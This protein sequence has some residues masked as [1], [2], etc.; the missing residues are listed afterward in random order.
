MERGKARLKGH[1]THG[2]TCSEV[3]ELYLEN[4]RRKELVAELA[5]E[6]MVLKKSLL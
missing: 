5:V 4:Q 1:E 6:N 3:K 2:A